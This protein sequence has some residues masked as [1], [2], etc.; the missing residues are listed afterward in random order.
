MPLVLTGATSGS[1][2]L[3]STDAVTNTLTLP[4]STGTL[5]DNNSSLTSANL[6]GALP[7]ID[8]SALTGL[9]APA[10]GR[11]VRTAGNITTTST[12]LVDVTGATVT[13]TTGAFPVAYGVVQSS[14][15]NTIS[16]R[17]LFN[18]AIDGVLQLGTSGLYD[19][20]AV[21]GWPQNTSFSGMTEALTAGSHTIKEQWK[22]NIGTLTLRADS[23]YSHLFYVH[24]VR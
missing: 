23:V 16:E 8:G 6:T 13:I 21:A 11:V 1:T 17:L 12:S 19:Q 22:T 18:I 24:E 15:N 2:T 5:L 14:M 20:Q 4:A 3:Q 10:F 9:P 7:A